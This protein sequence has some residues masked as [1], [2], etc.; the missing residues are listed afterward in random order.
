MDRQM[1]E[2]DGVNFRGVGFWAVFG[3]VSTFR[4][5]VS[6]VYTNDDHDR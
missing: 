5:L 6:M 2:L 1:R 4:F 3:D